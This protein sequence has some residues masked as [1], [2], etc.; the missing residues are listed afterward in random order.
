MQ[1]LSDEIIAALGGTGA[2]AKMVMAP[3][4][5]VHSWRH[6]IPPSRLDHLM[7]RAQ[8]AGIAVPWSTLQ[9]ATKRGAAEAT[10]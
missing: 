8:L 7:L 4:S 10:A 1:K 2:I 3:Q 6:Y 5:T 9:P